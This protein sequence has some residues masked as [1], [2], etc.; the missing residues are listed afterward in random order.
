MGTVESA[1]E[2][3]TT[4]VAEAAGEDKA[5]TER[6]G[7]RSESG[8]TSTPSEIQELRK[9]PQLTPEE[10]AYTNRNCSDPVTHNVV[11]TIR[12]NRR[13]DV[14]QLAW[15]LYG[16]HNLDKFSA[17][18]CV[19]I[20][21][22]H[23][24]ALIFSSGEC[25]ITGTK[26]INAAALAAIRLVN[27]IS[28]NTGV[29][30]EYSDLQVRNRMATVYLGYTINKDW[31]LSENPDVIFNE[32]SF[33]ALKIKRDF[34]TVLL[35]PTGSFV[36]TG[37]T[38]PEK[39]MMLRNEI[40]P[41]LARYKV[42]EATRKQQEENKRQAESLAA[43]AKELDRFAK[44]VDATRR[45]A[46][47]QKPKMYSHVSEAALPKYRGLVDIQQGYCFRPSVKK[48]YCQH[49]VWVRYPESPPEGVT[50]GKMALPMIKQLYAQNGFHF[51]PHRKTEAKGSPAAKKRPRPNDPP[52]KPIQGWVSPDGLYIMPHHRI[53]AQV[54]ATTKP[55]A[56]GEEPP[57]KRIRP[58]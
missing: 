52:A 19:K 20:K 21:E 7:A 28:S 34:G 13:F 39:T 9:T 45:R 57:P 50:L 51:P 42:V 49:H 55:S 54:T 30:V 26:S 35:F 27:L 17:P 3:I 5:A 46:R 24:A 1:I 2:Q 16:H 6:V 37:P 23:S 53:P 11:V 25:I 44:A 41:F 47:I 8:T 29:P 43:A 14:H 32:S 4:E 10:I 48:P 31:L 40:I 58:S 15:R 22:P 38:T 12:I 33:K 18:V 56:E 36:I